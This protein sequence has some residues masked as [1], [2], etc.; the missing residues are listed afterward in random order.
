EELIVLQ[1]FLDKPGIYL[2]EV[3]QE[4]LDITG[5]WISCATLCRLIPTCLFSWMKLVVNDGIQSADMG[6]GYEE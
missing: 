4:L 6:M 2:R 1:L 3:Q 5:T